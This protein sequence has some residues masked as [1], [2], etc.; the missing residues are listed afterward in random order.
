MN[1]IQINTIH[2]VIN[3]LEKIISEC[4]TNNNPLGYFAALY[5][6]VTKK[7]KEGIE[8]DFFDDGPRMEKL[9]VIFAKRYIDAYYGWQNNQTI[10]KSWQKAFEISVGYWPVVLQ[11]LLIGMNAHINLDLGIAAAEISK[12]KNIDDLQDDFMRINE[13]LSSLVNE[14][15]NNLAEI[16]PTLKKIL[17]KTNKADDFLVDFSMKLARDGAW[18]F[19]KTISETPENHIDK[20]L[21][22]RDEKVAE[23]AGLVINPGFVANLIFKIIRLGEKGTVASKINQLAKTIN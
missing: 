2:E 19:A 16:W 20:F 10:T 13:I 7:V 21:K 3:E 9:D 6:K 12:N 22:D 15:Q 18:K 1:T 14:V 23:K 5:Q 4:E 17:Q 8:N 11:H